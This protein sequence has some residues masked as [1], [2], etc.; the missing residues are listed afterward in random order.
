MI[1]LHVGWDDFNL[2]ILEKEMISRRAL[3]DLDLAFETLGHLARDCEIKG[4][5]LELPRGRLVEYRDKAKV[6]FL[7]LQIHN[8]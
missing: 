3:L 7:R 8:G 4:L 2:K 1:E 5:V 6:R